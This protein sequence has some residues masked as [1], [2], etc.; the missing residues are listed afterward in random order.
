MPLQQS[1]RGPKPS[2]LKISYRKPFI[3]ELGRVFVYQSIPPDSPARI[4]W[5]RFS[6]PYDSSYFCLSEL[7]TQ[8]P[9]KDKVTSR[10]QLERLEQRLL[11]LGQCAVHFWEACHW[12]ILLD[13]ATGD[14]LY[15]YPLCKDAQAQSEAQGRFFHAL[16]KLC[17]QVY[18]R[19]PKTDHTYITAA[20]LW[21]RCLQEF[22][23]SV[24]SQNMGQEPI[25]RSNK[26]ATAARWQN[27]R[28][29]LT[30]Q[31][32]NLSDWVRID[33]LPDTH[34]LFAAAQELALHP[35]FNEQHFAPFLSAFSL[36]EK[37]IKAN[38]A[39]FISTKD[40][41]LRIS[42]G[43]GKGSVVHNPTTGGDSLMEMLIDTYGDLPEL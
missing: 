31:K 24:S 9:Q 36:I 39:Y 34:Y 13:N 28:K 17:I 23:T 19:T 43:R 10:K 22:W 14:G 35:G 27:F 6:F 21:T 20:T 2:T 30:N 7:Q 37:D 42:T 11:G 26:T 29:M 5:E 38:P 15:R 41:R 3:D 32:E 1:K 16:L 8:L 33:Q 12:V 4:P 18:A 25:D 40:H